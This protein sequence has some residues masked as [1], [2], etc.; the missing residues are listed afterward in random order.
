M[1]FSDSKQKTIKQQWEANSIE[2]KTTPLCYAQQKA[3]VF[4][5][6]LERLMNTFVDYLDA[7][8]MENKRV[9][10]Y[11]TAMKEA[12]GCTTKKN[13]LDPF[14]PVMLKIFSN[15][16]GPAAAIYDYASIRHKHFPS[17]KQANEHFSHGRLYSNSFVDR[18]T[19]LDSLTFKTKSMLLNP[20]QRVLSALKVSIFNKVLDRY[21]DASG[22]MVYELEK[23]KLQIYRT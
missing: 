22:F 23:K 10:H 9:R 1:I 7:M 11:Q 17:Y 8:S 20:S 12:R 3:S 16:D 4:G 18:L 15:L 13:L 5:K 21:D 14:S 6:K 19:E 2:V